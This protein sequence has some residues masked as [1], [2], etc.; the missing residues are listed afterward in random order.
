V[1]DQGQQGYGVAFDETYVYWADSTTVGTITQVPKAGGTATVIAHDTQPLAVAVDTNNVYWSDV[2]GNGG[3]L[4]S[5]GPP[6]W[7][8]LGR[9]LDRL[10][11]IEMGWNHRVECDR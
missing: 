9:A 4:R 2:G 5:N 11:L 7:V 3:H 10:L 6:G 1:V 8:V